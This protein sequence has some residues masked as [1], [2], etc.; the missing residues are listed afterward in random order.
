MEQRVELEAK[1]EEKS[2]I[3]KEK[4]KENRKIATES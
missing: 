3:A 1:K 4:A 2:I